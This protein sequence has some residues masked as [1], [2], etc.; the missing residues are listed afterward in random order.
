VLLA[1][2]EPAVLRRAASPLLAMPAPLDLPPDA[3]R[4]L[5]ASVEA[6]EAHS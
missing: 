2:L 5:V 6:L 1:A 4:A 3:A